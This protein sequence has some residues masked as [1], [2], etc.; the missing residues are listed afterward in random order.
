MVDCIEDGRCLTGKKRTR[1]A[2]NMGMGLIKGYWPQTSAFH[3]ALTIVRN[4][5]LLV[6]TKALN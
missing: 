1:Q 5:F 4:K 6:V 2:K 3:A